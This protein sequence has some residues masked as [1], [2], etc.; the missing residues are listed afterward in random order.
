MCSKSANSE[1]GFFAF[2][3]NSRE[4]W[5]EMEVFIKFPSSW[6]LTELPSCLS[7]FPFLAKYTDGKSEPLHA[8]ISVHFGSFLPCSFPE[9][10]MAGFWNTCS[11][12]GHACISQII[13]KGHISLDFTL[14][15]LG[16]GKLFTWPI[17][18][19]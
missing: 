17:I 15:I 13:E 18:S 12:C 5:N 7:I 2:T 11:K 3:Y 10:Q 19:F 14:F 16:K 8:W 4:G 1:F 9:K 6:I